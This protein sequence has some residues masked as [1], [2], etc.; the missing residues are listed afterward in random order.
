MPNRI[1]PIQDDGIVERGSHEQLMAEDGRYMHP[2]SL[3]APEH[4]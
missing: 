1:I 4:R 2:C 3:P